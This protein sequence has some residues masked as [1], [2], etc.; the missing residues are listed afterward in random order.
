MTWERSLYANYTDGMLI[1]HKG[2][3]VYE[4]YFGCLE[5]VAST[6]SCR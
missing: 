4:R 6:P 3:V 1:L 5:E 2:E